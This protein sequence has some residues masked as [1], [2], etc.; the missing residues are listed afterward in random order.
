[1]KLKRIISGGQTGA[2]RT[3]LECA[4][5]LGFETGGWVPRGCKTES[6]IDKT[7]LDF[8]CVETA[9]A[10]YTVRT[11]WNTRDSDITVWFGN[12]YSP[13]YWC[14]FNGCRDHGKE[15]IINPPSLLAIARLY[16]VANIAGNRVSTNPRVVELVRAAFHPLEVAMASGG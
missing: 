15:M 16:E 9:D 5:A 10:G 4:K 14:T 13:G 3:A 11:K 12:Q 1:M 8:G 7:L 6:G 2:D